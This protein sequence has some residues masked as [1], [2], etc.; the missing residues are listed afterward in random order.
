[1]NA[2]M[3]TDGE[4]NEITSNVTIT[5][6]KV[7]VTLAKDQTV[8]ITG[9]P[10]GTTYTITEQNHDDYKLSSITNGGSGT[11]TANTIAEFV[12][13]NVEK[14]NTGNLVVTKL[15][16]HSYGDSYAIPDNTVFEI[17]VN[18]GNAFADRTLTNA[19]SESD[20]YLDGTQ[21]VGQSI[22][23]A[24]ADANGV[25]TFTFGHMDDVTFYN[26][27]EGTEYDVTETIPSTATG[28]TNQITY[29]EQEHKIVAEETHN[30]DV[31]NTYDP[32]YSTQVDI[33]VEVTKNLD[34]I[35]WEGLEAGA[36]F[37]FQ[38][39]KYNAESKS[40]NEVSLT[41]GASF[42]ISK[43][44]NA[45]QL[46]K[47]TLTK[48]QLNILANEVGTHYYRISEKTGNLSGITYDATHAYFRVIVTDNN[49]MDE[50][51]EY[52]IEAANNATLDGNTIKA[53]FTNRY[54]STTANIN[55]KKILENNTGV[56]VPMNSFEF[57]LCENENC[58]KDG[59]CTSS[60]TH[61]TVRPNVNGDVIIPM[62]YEAWN[63]QIDYT[64][65]Q[66]E[67]TKVYTQTYVY[68]LFEKPTSIAGMSCLTNQVKV[69]VTITE[70]VKI[71][72]DDSTNQ[73]SYTV[74][75]LTSTVKYED[76]DEVA[77]ENDTDATFKNTYELA[78]ATA[79][80]S[81]SKTFAGRDMNANEEFKFELYKATSEYQIEETTGYPKVSSSVK[82]LKNEESKVFSFAETF[83]EAGTYYYIV[84]E[85]VPADAA[86]GVK[87]GITYDTSEYRVEIKVTPHDTEQELEVKDENI[88]VF[89]AGGGANEIAFT[90]TY[91]ITGSTKATL[92]VT[93]V[94]TGR[95]L[96]EDEFKFSLYKADSEYNTVDNDGNTENGTTPIDGNIGHYANT[97]K[98]KLPELQYT[99]PGTYYY[100]LKENIP[101]ET[102]KLGGV[103]YDEKAINI[104][105][106]VSDNGVGG[107]AIGESDITYTGDAKFT[108]TYEAS[109]AD[110]VII[111]GEKFYVDESN[112]QLELKGGEFKFGLHETDDNYVIDLAKD[113]KHT[114]N[115]AN[116][117]AVDQF[118]FEL[119]FDKKGTYYYVIH[120]E[121]GDSPTIIYDTTIYHVMVVVLDNGS[122]KLNTLVNVTDVNGNRVNF[123]YGDTKEFKNIEKNVTPIDVPFNI[124]KTI[125]KTGNADHTLSGFEFEIKN[126]TT[127]EVYSKKPV[128]DKNGDALF[129]VQYTKADIGK[130]YTY[131]I[132]EINAGK[133][134]MIYDDTVYIVDVTVEYV[135]NNLA[136]IAELNGQIVENVLLEFEN[137]YSGK[138]PKPDP[139][140]DPGKDVTVSETPEYYPA[141]QQPTQGG[142]SAT[143]DSANIAIFAALACAAVLGLSGITIY[144]RK[145]N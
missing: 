13:T 99:A 19:V 78:S 77:V 64:A 4:Y 88:K 60:A 126:V 145:K 37:E 140:I 131:E 24:T 59:N 102:E 47:V 81:G 76:N 2:I 25:F 133:K 32:S 139:I 79:T 22:T 128:S 1:M 44:E 84:K 40:W 141:P 50:K 45:T 11:V 138:L 117:L 58:T 48:E 5:E 72:K 91:S 103:T 136:V 43:V 28:W 61:K 57:V 56:D 109:P 17:K 68:Y 53:T 54:N 30:I 66:N 42:E 114:T 108:N 121:L 118:A 14:P 3:V 8:Y 34:G 100:V 29:D 144:K 26:L 113:V 101:S 10:T 93:K 63:P 127:G 111:T 119:N 62:T 71:T 123:T 6:E 115:G 120:E 124:K 106:K 82:G 23:S 83:D 86:N 21:N 130:T 38:I 87:A 51:F 143:G 16:H 73:G 70:E 15:I 33:S 85:Q 107:L 12:A 97:G 105:V 125:V 7:T 39:E 98:L 94:L 55:I 132:R 134:N 46:T 69:T 90:N 142:G 31:K 104:S 80:I 18:L 52:T 67:E 75:K 41:N 96:K 116:G 92:D 112:Q 135:G 89:K 95:D 49:L 20:V 122:G 9:I 137:T 129:N 36:K 35:T 65:V 74:T 27:P 110:K